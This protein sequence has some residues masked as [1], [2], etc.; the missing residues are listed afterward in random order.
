MKKVLLLTIFISAVFGS[1]VKADK[2]KIHNFKGK[3][4]AGGGGE[5]IICSSP[6][7]ECVKVVSNMPFDPETG[8]DTKG[9]VTLFKNGDPN[10]EEGTFTFKSFT[11]TTEGDGEEMNTTLK[12]EGFEPK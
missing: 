10:Q 7:G 3:K 11:V 9:E 8:G 2:V 1:I 6:T 5:V 4:N 12:F